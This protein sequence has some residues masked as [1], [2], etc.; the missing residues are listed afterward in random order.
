MADVETAT[1]SRCGIPARTYAATTAGGVET[2]AGNHYKDVP[3]LGVHCQP[4]AEPGE[5]PV[6][7]GVAC[8]V[9]IF[10]E[11]AS[12]A[13]NEGGRPGAIVGRVVVAPVTTPAAVRFVDNLVT[14]GNNAL[15]ARRGFLWC[16]GPT[17]T[18][19]IRSIPLAV[20]VFRRICILLQLLLLRTPEQHQQ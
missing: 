18:Q 5:S 10:V 19:N 16:Y 14:C 17:V 13:E 4:L 9:R 11:H 15:N 7:I 3:P 1:A 2:N 20:H 12:F 6:Q 8:R